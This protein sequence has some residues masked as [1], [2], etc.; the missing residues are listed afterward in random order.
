ML[1]GFGLNL[2]GSISAPL[3][4]HQNVKVIKKKLVRRYKVNNHVN[5]ELP[6]CIAL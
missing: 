2:K 6:D 4:K 3:L 5:Y 1:S